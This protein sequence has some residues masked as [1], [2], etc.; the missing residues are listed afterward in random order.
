MSSLNTVTLVGHL[1]RKPELRY[2][3]THAAYA[4]FSLATNETLREK[5]QAP[6]ERTDWHRIVAWGR[7]TAACSQHLDVGRHVLVRGKLRTR[8]WTDREGVQRWSTEVLADRVIFLGT[9]A[10]QA[11]EPVEH[12]EPPPPEDAPPGADQEFPL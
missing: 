3:S 1:G 9:P 10:Q 12:L 2:T 5:G 4:I 8:F 6:R 11:S 7:T